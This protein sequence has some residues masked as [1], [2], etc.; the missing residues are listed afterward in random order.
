MVK[1]VSRP[2]SQYSLDALA[3]LGQLV[4]EAR[5]GSG[6]TT[7]DLAARAGISRGLLQRIERGDPGCTVGVVFEVATLCGVPLFD[8]GQRQLT[9][10]LDLHREKMALLPRAVRTHPQA[11]KDDF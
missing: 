8:Q 10:L 9:T 2:Y 3:L 1:P 4:R 6:I 7:T 5:V 11:V